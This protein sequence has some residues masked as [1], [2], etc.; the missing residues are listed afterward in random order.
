[1]TKVLALFTGYK[2]VLKVPVSSVGEAQGASHGD[3]KAVAS[4][5]RRVRR[6]T[7]K[8]YRFSPG[9][10]RKGYTD[11]VPYLDMTLSEYVKKVENG[12]TTAEVKKIVF[13][14]LKKKGFRGRKKKVNQGIHAVLSEVRKKRR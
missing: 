6:Q 11:Y 7:K 2:M 9:S 8:K 13:D 4:R 10:K 12:K 3:G 5:T 1:M 14:K